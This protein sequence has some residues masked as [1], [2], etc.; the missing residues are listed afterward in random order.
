MFDDSSLSRAGVLDGVQYSTLPGSDVMGSPA[1]ETDDVTASSSKSNRTQPPV[2]TE[3][4]W[5]HV[6]LIRCL[7]TSKVLFFAVQ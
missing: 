1:S 2:H 5:H 7:L 6:G 4:T 3:V